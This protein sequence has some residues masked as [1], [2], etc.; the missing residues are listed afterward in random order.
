MEK[1]DLTSG[2]DP[3]GRS[4]DQMSGPP[5]GRSSPNYDRNEQGGIVTRT[6]IPG[7]AEA[8][9]N[10]CLESGLASRRKCGY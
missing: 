10:P 1:P 5:L 9:S 4:R 2:S 6:H 3:D 8:E 7:E